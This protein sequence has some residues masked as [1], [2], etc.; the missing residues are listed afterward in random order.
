MRTRLHDYF[1]SVYKSL[2]YIHPHNT[3]LKLPPSNSGDCVRARTTGLQENHSVSTYKALVGIGMILIEKIK[4]LLQTVV[5]HS[6]AGLGG[7]LQ[8]RLLGR[9]KTGRG[10]ARPDVVKH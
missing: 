3:V 5:P 6:A 9:L 10:W 7:A 1:N 4:I 8:T 2:H